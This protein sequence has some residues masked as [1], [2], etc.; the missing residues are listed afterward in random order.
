VQTKEV[1]MHVKGICPKCGKDMK[2]TKHHILPKRHFGGRN[3]NLL[4]FLCR[5][6]HSKLELDISQTKILTTLEYY[7][8]IIRFLNR[9]KRHGKKGA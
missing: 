5:Q 4:F 3:N 1:I 7:Q 2:L 6:C 9:S 8:I